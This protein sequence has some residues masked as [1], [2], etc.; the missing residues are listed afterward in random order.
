MDDTTHHDLQHIVNE[1]T[2]SIAEA[3]PENSFERLFW[4]QQQQSLQ[5][6]GARSMRWHPLMI[7]WC[8][9]LRHLSGKAYDTLRSS[10]CIRLPSQRTLRDYTHC[11]SA[12][13]GFSSAVDRQLMCAADVD[14]CPERQKYVALILDEMYV[15]E[16][17]VYNKHSGAFIGFHDLGNINEHLLQFQAS[18]EDDSSDT[19]EQLAKTMLVL[20]VRGLLS[21][22]EFPYV[23]FPCAT[24]T[25]DLLFDPLWKA[26]ARIERCG[27]KVL[28]VTADGASPNRRLFKIHNPSSSDTSHKVKNPYSTD[29]R[30]LFFLSDPPHLLKTTRNCFASKSRTLWVSSHITSFSSLGSTLVVPISVHSA[31]GKRSAGVTLFAYT[32]TTMVNT[33]TRLGY[34]AWFTSSSMSIL[35]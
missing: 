12:T 29:G 22:L 16:D 26:I 31:R 1:N 23:Q 2:S 30:D 14:K 4:E 24:M 5:L 8:L 19:N 32:T 34:R 6:K 28:A 11:V 25:G 27:L 13:T 18:L 21:G 17:L 33:Q 9:Y 15:K 3:F 7:K 35:I 20:M 10:G